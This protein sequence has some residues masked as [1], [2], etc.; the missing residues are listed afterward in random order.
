[1]FWKDDQKR[2]TLINGTM[3]LAKFEISEGVSGV[4]RNG[5]L[6]QVC[7]LKFNQPPVVKQAFLDGR[8]FFFNLSRL[9]L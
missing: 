9:F 1:M 2:G 3:K 8:H 4:F 5:F 6:W 7:F